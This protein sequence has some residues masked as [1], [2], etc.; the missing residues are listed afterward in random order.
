MAAA[1]AQT[2]SVHE[3]SLT[4]TVAKVSVT[5]WLK[6]SSAGPSGPIGL[7]T[8]RPPFCAGRPSARSPKV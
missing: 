7:V 2:F 6:A 1:M 8:A 3:G 4:P 5:W